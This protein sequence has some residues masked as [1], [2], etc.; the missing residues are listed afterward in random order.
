ME[1]EPRI[2][3]AVIKQTIENGHE[4]GTRSQVGE[5]GQDVKS[6]LLLKKILKQ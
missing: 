6:S 3:I 4:R 2:P 1:T 5:N